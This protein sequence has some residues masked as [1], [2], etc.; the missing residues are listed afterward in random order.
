MVEQII[1]AG[2][3]FS[4]YYRLR[5]TNFF[6]TFFKIKK[7]LLIIIFDVDKLFLVIL[8]DNKNHL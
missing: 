2:F 4:L 5:Q 3:R 7:F 6:R 1:F 8:F